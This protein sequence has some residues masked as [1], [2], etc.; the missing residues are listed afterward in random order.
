ML[1]ADKNESKDRKAKKKEPAPAPKTEKVEK[2]MVEAAPSTKIPPH[3]EEKK[4]E[5]HAQPAAAAKQHA[6]P[7]L[8]Q[9]AQPAAPQHAHPTVPQHAPPAV[10][11]E[12]R[13]PTPEIKPK[14]EKRKKTRAPIKKTKAFVARGKRKTSVARATV[15]AGKGIVRINSM[16]VNSLNNPYVRDI[17]LEPLR[18]L[19]PEANAIDISINVNGG[20]RMGQAQAARTAIANALIGFFD[21][22]DLKT[23]FIDIDRSLVVED[24]RR[25]ETKKYKGPKARARFQKSYR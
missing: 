1:M 2:K 5:T 17:I 18:Y 3:K 21:T 9:H 8:V 20:G 24:T 25:V 10:P 14:T 19:G 13:P 6:Q 7:A 23:K 12:P 11:P 16:N 4:A 15:I 22:M